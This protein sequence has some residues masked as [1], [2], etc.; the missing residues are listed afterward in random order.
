LKDFTPLAAEALLH[1]LNCAQ[2]QG[3]L[4]YAL[5]VRVTMVGSS[6]AERRRFFRCLKFQR[7]LSEIQEQEGAFSVSLSGPLRLF[8]N[9][10]SYGIRLANF[11]PYILQMPKW[12][13]EAEVKL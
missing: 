4:I 9:T 8:Q 5:D 2:V 10:Q 6:L 13:L 12:E 11:F 1:R 3:L 7:L